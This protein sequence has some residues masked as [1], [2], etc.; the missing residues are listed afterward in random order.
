LQIQLVLQARAFCLLEMLCDR[1][2]CLER[3]TNQLMVEV[4]AHT[5]KQPIFVAC[6]I[7]PLAIREGETLS[8]SAAFSYSASSD[9]FSCASSSCNN[10]ANT[11]LQLLDCQYRLDPLL[12]HLWAILAALQ[13]DNE[14]DRS[15]LK[16]LPSV[17]DIRHRTNQ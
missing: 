10:R 2:R 14:C 5:S 6:A 7:N 3:I 13:I 12:L 11:K 15:A 16:Q 17:M 4:F 9:G 1:Y 8:A